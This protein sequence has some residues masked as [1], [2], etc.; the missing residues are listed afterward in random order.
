[1]LIYNYISIISIITYTSFELQSYNIT[2]PLAQSLYV[3]QYIY[4]KR[5]LSGILMIG[6]YCPG[7]NERT[8]MHTHVASTIHTTSVASQNDAELNS[9][10]TKN[11]QTA[12][13]YKLLSKPTD[14]S[15]LS[16]YPT[17]T[18]KSIASTA[19][20]RQ[21]IYIDQYLSKPIDTSKYDT[22]KC[23]RLSTKSNTFYLS[24]FAIFYLLQFTVIYCS[25]IYLLASLPSKI[26]RKI[27]SYCNDRKRGRS[28]S[29]VINSLKQYND[30][31]KIYAATL[32]LG[33][34]FVLLKSNRKP[35]T[36]DLFTKRLSVESSYPSAESAIALYTESSNAFRYTKKK[37][38]M[39][40]YLMMT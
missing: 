33:R 22:S 36:S 38:L 16:D 27:I 20:N 7:S 5:I 19:K 34:S 32:S 23:T 13:T 39:Q 18:C 6:M 28:W 29:H 26:L 21:T 25:Q 12:D 14:T 8:I 37:H 15:K 35:D 30:A 40:H 9:C 2:Y 1:M 4:M 3:I 10:H 31:L 17:D 24:Q 11:R